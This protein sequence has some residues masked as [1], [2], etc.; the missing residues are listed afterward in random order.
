MPAR[1]RFAR[2]ARAALVLAFVAGAAPPPASANEID[3]LWRAGVARADEMFAHPGLDAMLR[4]TLG[5][6]FAAFQTLSR[7]PEPV[8]RHAGRIVTGAACAAAG[9]AAGGVFV[10]ADT[11]RGEIQ[12]HLAESGGRLATFA[13]PGFPM[14]SESV[15]A[16]LAAWRAKHAR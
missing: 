9:C 16:A 12:V 10:V 14:A 2:A 15:Q 8:A 3:T 5:P 7:T 6:R 4:R 1:R 11:A 13:S